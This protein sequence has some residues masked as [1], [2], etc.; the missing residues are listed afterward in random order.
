MISPAFYFTFVIDIRSLSDGR[1]G[2][3]RLVSIL[4]SIVLRNA[5]ILSLS[6]VARALRR[7]DCFD[8]PL[9]GAVRELAPSAAIA[10]V[11]L[12]FDS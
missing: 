12:D 9:P 1:M 4:L 11:D 6:S 5:T 3:M 7:S 8:C 10:H 2:M